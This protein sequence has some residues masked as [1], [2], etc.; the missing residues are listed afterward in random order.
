MYKQLFFLFFKNREFKGILELEY[1][2]QKYIFGQSVLADNPD[3]V[4]KANLVVKKDSFFKRTIL[5]GSIGFGEAYMYE[6]FETNN[7]KDL[8]TWFLQNRKALPAYGNKSLLNYLFDWLW[9]IPKFM[10]DFRKNTKEGSSKNIKEHYDISN[11]FYELWLDK[12]MTY[13]SAIFWD[14]ESLKQAQENKYRRL[15]EKINLKKGDQLLE[16]GSGW[17]ALAIFAAQNYDCQVT[18]VTISEKQYE[19]ASKKI[20][21]LGLQDKINIKLQDYRDI[22]GIYDKIISIEMMEA[23]GHEYVTLFIKKCNELLKQGGKI[24]LQCITYPDAK[25]KDYLRKSDFIQK[26]IFPGGELLSVLEVLKA[27]KKTGQLEL[28]SLENIGQSYART[29]ELWHKNFAE[30][31]GQIKNLGFSEV[32]MRKWQFYLISCEVG[33]RQKLFDDAQIFIE[34]R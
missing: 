33:F 8:L 20:E 26:H 2:G 9:L 29:L 11:D 28:I 34:K 24:G 30:K 7:L 14:K 16:I 23:L 5:F 32:F 22:S 25:F 1:K 13:S 3:L 15:C 21:S 12:S 10:H 19:Y 4:S 31:E 27:I 6:D 18:T 17:G